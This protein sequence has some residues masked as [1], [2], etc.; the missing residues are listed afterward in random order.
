MMLNLQ[1]I[2]ILISLVSIIAF[3]LFWFDKKQAIARNHRISEKT[4]LSV[5]FFGGT[6]GSVLSMILFRHKTSKRSFLLKF[7]GVV[8]LQI[9]VIYYFLLN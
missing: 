6:I 4:L 7:F 9:V 2:L 1:N 3:F 8:V 5:T